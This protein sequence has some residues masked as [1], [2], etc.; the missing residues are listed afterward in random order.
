[1]CERDVLS[2]QCL[3]LC[4]SQIEVQRISSAPKYT[5][6]CTS[7][8]RLSW[9]AIHFTLKCIALSLEVYIDWAAY[10]S[11]ASLQCSVHCT[12]TAMQQCSCSVCTSEVVQCIE[13]LHCTG[14]ANALHLRCTLIWEG[15]YNGVTHTWSA[16]L[17]QSPSLAWIEPL[18][19]PFGTSIF[20]CILFQSFVSLVIR[21]TAQCRAYAVLPISIAI[22]DVHIWPNKCNPYARSWNSPFVTIVTRTWRN[23]ST[24]LCYIICLPWTV[25]CRNRTLG[26]CIICLCT[27]ISVDLVHV[28]VMLTLFGSLIVKCNPVLVRCELLFNK[29]TIAYKKQSVIFLFTNYVPFMPT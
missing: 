17:A 15:T 16:G 26:G 11:C 14:T 10:T 7:M 20:L 28:M 4:Q 24:P 6:W 21:L 29:N 27:G 23:E 13:E 25:H 1:M 8:I 3:A 19:W 5:L 18:V 2:S 22:W 9:S 12:Y